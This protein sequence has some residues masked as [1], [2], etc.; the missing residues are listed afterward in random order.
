MPYSRSV[1]GVLL[2][3]VIVF[4]V[5]A[6]PL[7]VSGQQDTGELRVASADGETDVAQGDSQTVEVFYDSPSSD[8]PRVIEF[9]LTYDQDVLSVP[10]NGVSSGGYLGAIVNPNVSNGT[11]DY[12]EF[13]FD[14]NPTVNP[15][16]PVA[17]IEFT[18]AESASPDEQTDLTL[19]NVSIRPETLGTPKTVGKTITVVSAPETG[20]AFTISDLSPTADVQPGGQLTLRP[21]IT[22]ERQ[23]SAS[24][25][26]TFE[27][28]SE[29]RTSEL[30]LAG[31]ES[32]QV[33][34]TLPAPTEP[35]NVTYNVSTDSDFVTGE[36][37]VRETTSDNNV[38]IQDSPTLSPTPIDSTPSEHTLNFDV[39]N[40]S[41]DNETD[42]FTVT[43]PEEVTVEDITETTVTDAGG[44]PIKVPDDP[45]EENDPGREIKFT[46]NPDSEET[47]VK[48]L[49]VE[50]TME[51]SATP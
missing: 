27:L 40:V 24:E 4:G 43:L 41:A 22:N 23:Q 16:Q 46:V 35:G 11:V 44:N 5:V 34:E 9:N 48:T 30:T 28:G 2:V 10:E 39:A 21:T 26:V 51:L 14:E 50:V 37:T 17:T 20:S 7:A 33:S 19:T 18:P 1:F 15:N 47:A 13:S 45:A 6:G 38:E 3:A 25:T 29:R 31:G 8:T 32:T 42:E 12:F 36:I 49:T